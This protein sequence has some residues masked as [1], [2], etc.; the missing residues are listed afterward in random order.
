MTR[1]VSGCSHS[2]GFT[3][4]ELVTIL[5]LVGI[6]AVTVLPRFF[7]SDSVAAQAVRTQI[8]GQLRLLQ[9]QTMNQRQGCQRFVVTVTHF[10]LGACDTGLDEDEDGILLDGVSIK[11]GSNAT[12]DVRFDRQGRPQSVDG[13]CHSSDNEPGCDL[14]VT[15]EQSLTVR[16]EPEGYIHAL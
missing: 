3:L 4:I 8:V 7:T 11:I 2:A 13:D 16:I 10:G 15:L 12:P 1:N 14:I 5:I 9:L 6:L